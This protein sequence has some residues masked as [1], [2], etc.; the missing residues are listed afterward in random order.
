MLQVSFRA[1]GFISM[2]SNKVSFLRFLL[3]VGEIGPTAGLTA[4][5]SAPQLK[6]TGFLLPYSPD[7]VRKAVVAGAL[8]TE[9]IG[10]PV[11]FTGARSVADAMMMPAHFKGILLAGEPPT[12]AGTTATRLVLGFNLSPRTLPQDL[13]ADAARIRPRRGESLDLLA[14]FCQGVQPVSFA[15]L[16]GPS[17]SSIELKDFRLQSALILGTIMPAGPQ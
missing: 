7:M 9:V 13:C 3:L 12:N 2:R 5:T 8:P 15:R 16:L 11:E 17:Y 10:S 1:S 6:E 14:V 4:C